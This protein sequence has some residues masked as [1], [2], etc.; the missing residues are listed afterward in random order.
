[1]NRQFNV[2]YR[3]TLDDFNVFSKAQMRLTRGRCFA[4]IILRAFVVMLFAAAAWAFWAGNWGLAVYFLVLGLALVVTWTVVA[5]WQRRRSFEDQRLGEFDVDFSADEEGFTSKSELGEGK[6]KWSS[7]R[8][9]DDLADHILLWPNK[10]IGLMVPKRA[11]ATR[12]DAEAFVQFAK[13]KTV[14]QTL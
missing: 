10:R 11:F 2:R 12:A 7:I 6:L 4:Y 14:G 5:P 13:E 3:W 9:V 8:K 1:M